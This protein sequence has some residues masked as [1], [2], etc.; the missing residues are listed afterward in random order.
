MTKEIPRGFD[1]FNGQNKC[2]ICGHD[3]RY[4]SLFEEK[5]TKCYCTGF[6]IE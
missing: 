6:V 4:H 5:C 3:E 1:I 2:F